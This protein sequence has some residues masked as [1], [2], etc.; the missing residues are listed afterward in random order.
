MCGFH[1][2]S[3]SHVTAEEVDPDYLELFNPHCRIFFN[4]KTLLLSAL[5]VSQ[6]FG[7]E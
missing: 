5:F 4:L 1:V 6:M 2:G 3:K 7:H